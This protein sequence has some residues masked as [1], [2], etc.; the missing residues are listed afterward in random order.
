MN[1][2]TPM[3]GVLNQF[4]YCNGVDTPFITHKF[5]EQLPTALELAITKGV[6]ST[7]AAV[8]GS[9][10]HHTTTHSGGN[11]FPMS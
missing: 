3:G 7:M 4:P 2:H 6:S 11:H 10:N 1:Q 9:A 5:I 8:L